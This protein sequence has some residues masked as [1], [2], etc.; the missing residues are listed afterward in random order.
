[1]ASATT[2]VQSESAGN[3]GPAART[4]YDE[5]LATGLQNN[6]T[7]DE[8]LG[9]G[10]RTRARKHLSENGAQP[11]SGDDTPNSQAMN[12]RES[13]TDDGDQAG[14]ARADAQVA[15]E[16]AQFREIFDANPELRDAW[17]ESHAYK[18]SFT[19]PE[20]AKLATG[21]IADLR[22][23]DT[24]FFSKD[25][26]D[27]AELA[28]FVA[29]LDAAAFNSLAEAMGRVAKETAST[30]GRRAAPSSN[31]QDSHQSITH[32]AIAAENPGALNASQQQFL[33]T[34]NAAAVKGV[35]EAIESQ[36]DRLLPKS[37]SQTARQ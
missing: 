21:Q 14:E 11:E 4:A 26:K 31:A 25:A 1:M 18:E 22:A 3:P 28:R 17:R 19:T 30:I 7:D 16:P 23:M 12:T 37:I 34:T 27:H 29:K 32:E 6:A 35:V 9:L 36:I 33:Q 20:E 8:I 13:E 15:D 10:V 5:P 24:L 2:A